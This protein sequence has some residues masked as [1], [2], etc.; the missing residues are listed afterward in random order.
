MRAMIIT[1]LLLVV[2]HAG[3]NGLGHGTHFRVRIDELRHCI[4]HQ[5]HGGRRAATEVQFAGGGRGEAANIV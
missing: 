4:R 5:F 2:G 1:A 3:A